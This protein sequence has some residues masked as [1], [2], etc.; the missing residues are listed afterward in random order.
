M[1][2]FIFELGQTVIIEAS[3]ET[4]RVIARAEYETSENGYLIRYKAG[5]GRATEAWWTED[6]L[7]P[8]TL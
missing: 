3:G 1:D 5:D 6:A 4:G 2:K 7:I 8:A